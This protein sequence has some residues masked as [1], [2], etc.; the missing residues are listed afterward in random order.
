M[1]LFHEMQNIG[2]TV[3]IINPERSPS[4]SLYYLGSIV[5]KILLENDNLSIE[6]LFENLQFKLGFE[7]HIDF[8]YYTLDWLYILSAI[9]LDKERVCLCA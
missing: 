2:D 4:L 3:M 8:F 6:N 5:L 9:K 7:L 1:L